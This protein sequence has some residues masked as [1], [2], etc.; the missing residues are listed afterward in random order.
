MYWEENQS[1]QAIIAVFWNNME[2]KFLQVK[3]YN[4]WQRWSP[5]AGSLFKDL[6]ELARKIVCNKNTPLPNS[7]QTA[8]AFCFFSV[9]IP[10]PRFL[11]R[12][13]KIFHCLI[14][15]YNTIT[16]ILMC[17]PWH[18]CTH[19]HTHPLSWMH[20]LLTLWH[21]WFTQRCV[22]MRTR[23]YIHHYCHHLAAY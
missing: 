13:M 6:T 12:N 14:W 10:P 15:E 23:T 17:H 8:G 7:M 16:H 4:E 20:A 5:L 2:T 21:T 9:W 18:A 3:N 22:L 11:F 1:E 19:T